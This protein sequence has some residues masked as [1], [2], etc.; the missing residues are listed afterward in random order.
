MAVTPYHDSN[1]RSYARLPAALGLI[2]TLVLCAA[3]MLAHL[4]PVQ[5]KPAAA[6]LWVLGFVTQASAF[7]LALATRRAD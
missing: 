3:A 1:E 2:G 6:V 5:L 4:S 7:M